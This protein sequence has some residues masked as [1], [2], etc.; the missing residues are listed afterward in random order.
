MSKQN[1]IDQTAYSHLT[2]RGFLK[3]AAASLGAAA[4]RPWDWLAAPHS[5]RPFE[6]FPQAERL[7]RVF[8]YTKA[9]VKALPDIDSATVAEYY[10]DSVVPWLREVVGRNPY[11]YRQS[12]VETPKGYIWAPFLQPVRNLPNIP[13][14][15][16]PTTSLGT[17]MWVEVSVPWVDIVLENKPVSPGF[18]SRTEAG[19]PLRLYYSQLLWVDRIKTDDK[20]QV[21]YRCNERF[22]YGDLM[23]AVGEAFRPLTAEEMTPLSPNVEDK[24]VVVNVEEKY[25]TLSCYEGKTEVYFCR[26][27]GGKRFDSEGT[28]LEHSATPIGIHQIWRKQVSA[29]M[30]GGTTGAGYDLPGIGW[31]TLFS[32]EGVAVH[33][34]FWHNNFGGEL[35]SHGCVNAAPED[36]K[37]VFRWTNPPV[38]YDPGDLYSKDTKIPPTRVTVVEG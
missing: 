8:T 36:A 33:S 25:Q 7:G 20:G 30:S 4:F 37:W 24:S 21:W 29:H 11:R 17:G 34:T 28:P 38:L 23:W 1:V 5:L 14:T 18:V 10:D 16:L 31:T 22:G 26:I 32:S 9:E 3:L 6:D 19:F 15:K 35:M 27:S 13:V 2:R 12:F